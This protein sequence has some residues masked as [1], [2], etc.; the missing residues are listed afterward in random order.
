VQHLRRAAAV[1]R[2]AAH[3]AGKLSDSRV[4]DQPQHRIRIHELDMRAAGG[5]TPDHDVAR[6]QRADLRLGGECLAGELR[7]AGA[8]DLV[9]RHVQPE[10]GLQGGGDVDLRQ[11]AEA[12]LGE[13]LGDLLDG[14]VECHRDGLAECVLAH[15]DL[16]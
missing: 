13:F 16:R 2:A 12:F 9:G 14:R 15:C 8:E 11:H 10:L 3:L 1:A 4:I 5:V 7:V 6:Q